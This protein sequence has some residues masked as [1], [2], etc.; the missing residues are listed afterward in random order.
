MGAT[1]IRR[2]LWKFPRFGKQ[3]LAE[4][5]GARGRFTPRRLRFL[6]KIGVG[7]LI[8]IWLLCVAWVEPV[9]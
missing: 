1:V 5:T 8:I 2:R 7:M 6:L 4:G 9:L 3:S